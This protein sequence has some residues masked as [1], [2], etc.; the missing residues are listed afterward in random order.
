MNNDK[1]NVIFFGNCSLILD[2]LVKNSNVKS[3]FC[4]PEM[5]TDEYTA[6][7]NRIANKYFIPLK[8]PSKEDLHNYI[9]YIEESSPDLIV[10]CGYKYIIPSKIFDIPKFRSINIHPSYLPKYRGQHVINWAIINGEKETGIT[11][12]YIDEGV[13]AGDIIVQKK[14]PILFEDTAKML[15][16]R[17]YCEAIEL[18]QH[19]LS[20]IVSGNTL[21][22][23]KQ[24]DAKA[25][26]FRPRNPVDGAINWD[27]NG[28]EIYNLIRAL[29]KPWPG[30][31]SY[32]RGRKIIIWDVQFEANSQDS[33]VGEITN[34]LNSKL[35]I[36]VK[37]G[38]LMVSDYTMIDNNE[39]VKNLRIEIGDKFENGC[40]LN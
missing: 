26:Y 24:D 40:D 6:K 3:I 27:K 30:A 12:H 38:K 33:S 22:A 18:L 4:G 2:Y 36:T 11:V 19:V 35:M 21:P 39:N 5:A 13:D 29:V 9:Q 1:I 23:Q 10:S 34:V 7:I 28:I 37:G 32:I 25:S 16:D 8:R 20:T 17:I 31:Y 15:H 14:V